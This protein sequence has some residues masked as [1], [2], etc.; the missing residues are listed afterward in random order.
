M[1]KLQTLFLPGVATLAAHGL[2]IALFSYFGQFQK[3][4]WKEATFSLPVYSVFWIC[5]VPIGSL[6]AYLSRRAGGSYSDRILASLFIVIGK[7]IGYILL[8][9]LT[10]LISGPSSFHFVYGGWDF[11][12][13]KYIIAPG[14]ALA[15]GA[16]LFLRRGEN[17]PGINAKTSPS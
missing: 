3:T 13:G 14:L 16:A 15:L 4:L 17:L 7:S 9:P 8:V 12:L 6:G 11:I 2:L 5:M 10:L 1:R